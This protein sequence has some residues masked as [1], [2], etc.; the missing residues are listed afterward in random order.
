MDVYLFTA[1]TAGAINKEGPNGRVSFELEVGEIGS[2]KVKQWSE[3]YF[4][5]KS[6]HAVY[7]QP[8]PR[9]YSHD[10]LT[11]RKKLPRRERKN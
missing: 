9:V 2:H 11:K 7:K 3:D 10:V 8:K 6:K 4:I 5:S 1:K